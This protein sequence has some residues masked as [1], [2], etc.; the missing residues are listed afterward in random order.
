VGRYLLA[1]QFLK[2]GSNRLDLLLS[3]GE[4]WP[5]CL[6]GG[7]QRVHLLRRVIQ[8]SR[9]VF[10]TESARI[11]WSAV[12]HL[13]SLHNLQEI[14]VLDA[15]TTDTFLLCF[16]LLPKP[17]ASRRGAVIRVAFVLH[18]REMPE[19]QKL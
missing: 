1:V 17:L 6:Q 10:V 13:E 2:R 7:Q 4:G 11:L 15:S 3:G 16:W 8:A 18:L 14:E 5:A 9:Q 19:K 12:M